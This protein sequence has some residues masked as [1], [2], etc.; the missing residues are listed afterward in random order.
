M[1]AMIS[2]RLDRKASSLLAMRP[3]SAWARISCGVI[4][5]WGGGAWKGGGM[6]ERRSQNGLRTEWAFAAAS[7]DCSAGD[8][9]GCGVTRD[10]MQLGARVEKQP[11]AN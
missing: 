9:M 8:A 11:A 3:A 10:V 5:C 4:L 2:S 6:A 7:T 1:S